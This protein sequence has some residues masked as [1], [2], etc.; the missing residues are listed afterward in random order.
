MRHRKIG[1]KLGRE[2]H[3]RKA[4]LRSLCTSL[5]KYEQIETTVAKAKE[6]KRE[7][8]KAVTVAK[9]MNNVKGET[10][11][12]T[13]ALKA[14]K[15]TILERFFHGCEDRELLGRDQIKK[16]I[17][18]LKK[19]TRE[20]VEKYMSA[21]EK[22]PKPDFII[23]YIP[24]TTSRTVICRDGSEKKVERKNAPKIMRIE[25][26][27]TKLINRIV[28]RFEQRT[29]GYTKIYKSRNRR[30]DNAEMAIIKF[31]D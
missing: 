29:G 23:D 16:Y 3:Q 1:R 20:M 31:T 7:I 21:P 11:Q 28:P 4:L 14:S 19:E 8:E 25:G 5:V 17:S 15:R 26:T 10:E 9:K 24:S 13:K 27:L 18:N 30:G 12:Q 22:N 6:L 2:S